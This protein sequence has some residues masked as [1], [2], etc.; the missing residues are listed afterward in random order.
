MLCYCSSSPVQSAC[1][2]VSLCVCLCVA[3]KPTAGF[4][5]STTAEILKVA[6]GVAGAA[7]D[8]GVAVLAL[9][10]AIFQRWNPRPTH[11]H[12]PPRPH[13]GDT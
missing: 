10:I 4:S 2:F 12:R 1:V 6:Q 7:E 11:A 8:G 13:L 5:K 9:S 3:T